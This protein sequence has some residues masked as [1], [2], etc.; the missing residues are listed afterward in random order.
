MMNRMPNLIGHFL[1]LNGG[2]VHTSRGHQL[3]DGFIVTGQGLPLLAGPM[4]FCSGARQHE[5]TG[6]PMGII[7]KLIV[8][9]NLALAH[10]KEADMTVVAGRKLSY[11]RHWSRVHFGSDPP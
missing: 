11:K 10:R 6:V 2:H 4:A 5:M 7:A 8:T 3:L 1:L 9:V